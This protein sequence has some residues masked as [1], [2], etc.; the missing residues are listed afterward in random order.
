VKTQRESERNDGLVQS[1]AI[2]Y[3]MNHEQKP[4]RVFHGWS[5]YREGRSQL[6][7]ND[8]P[9]WVPRYDT[10]LPKG[11][12]A[13]LYNQRGITSYNAGGPL[14]V[15]IPN[16]IVTK[17]GAYKLQLSGH[18]RAQIDRTFSIPRTAV[19]TKIYGRLYWR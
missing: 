11:S 6:S 7:N 16:E 17:D 10:R 18:Y 5:F 13:S 12:P 2:I 19:A 8:M 14:R 9:S 3:L 4:S 15:N 1:Q